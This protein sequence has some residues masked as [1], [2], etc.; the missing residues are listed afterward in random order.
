MAQSNGLYTPDMP[1]RWFIR[2]SLAVLSVSVLLW[3][4]SIRSLTYR[5]P[6]YRGGVTIQLRAGLLTVD[7][8]G[9]Y[10]LPRWQW[11]PPV[12]QLEWWPADSRFV[13]SLSG[14]GGPSHRASFPL[15]IPAFLAATVLYLAH[16]SRRKSFPSTP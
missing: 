16:R 9:S 2:L 3:L 12:T 8:R 10:T 11:G 6:R 14:P 15:W 5:S 1:R 13:N 7:N 4:A